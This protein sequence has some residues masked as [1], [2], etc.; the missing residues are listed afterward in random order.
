MTAVIPLGNSSICC[1]TNAKGFARPTKW[2]S[3]V[4]SVIINWATKDVK[5]AMYG[6]DCRRSIV[7]AAARS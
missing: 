7:H 4:D 1:P 2:Q 3:T 6:L 5:H